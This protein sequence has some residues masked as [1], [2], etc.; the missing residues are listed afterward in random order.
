VDPI[1]VAQAGFLLTLLNAAVA[2]TMFST[3]TFVLLR[4]AN[5]LSH[6][7]FKDSYEIVMQNPTALAIYLSVRYAVLGL[8]NAL[9]IASIFKYA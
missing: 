8:G 1:Q 9:I 7:T 3:I 2:V 4:I 5:A 6:I